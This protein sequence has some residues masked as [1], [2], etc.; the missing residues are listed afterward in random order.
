MSPRLKIEIITPERIVYRGE[1]D[2]ISLPGQGGEL[3]ILPGH[4]PLISALKSGEIT[5]H[6]GSDRRH[7]AIHGGFVEVDQQSVRLLTDSAE[8]EEEIDER[9]AHEAVERARRARDQ[10]KDD[11]TTADALGALERA[12]TRLKLAERRKLRHRT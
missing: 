7:M 12:L 11:I 8:L 2:G 3:T 10:A 9:R 6:T 4:V 5:L 1:A